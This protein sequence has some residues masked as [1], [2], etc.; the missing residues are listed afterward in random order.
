[1][2]AILCTDHDFEYEVYLEIAKKAGQQV[3]S[4]VD[5]HGRVVYYI[6]PYPIKNYFRTFDEQQSVKTGTYTFE[7][8][9]K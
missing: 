7:S 5:E 6:D 1:M 9:K 2:K 3:M 8:K 4:E